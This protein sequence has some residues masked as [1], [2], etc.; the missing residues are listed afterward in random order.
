MARYRPVRILLPSDPASVTVA[1]KNFS[2]RPPTVHQT[3]TVLSSTVT[4]STVTNEGT[5]MVDEVTV[6]VDELTVTV[7]WWWTV[8]WAVGGREVTF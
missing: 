1:F 3:V 4:Q 2:Y 7:G 5:V 8:G 6:T